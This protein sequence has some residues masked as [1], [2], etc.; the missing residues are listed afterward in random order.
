MGIRRLEYLSLTTKILVI[1]NNRVYHGDVM[2]IGKE[3]RSCRHGEIDCSYSR[4]RFQE[5][6]GS[7]CSQSGDDSITHDH[8]SITRDAE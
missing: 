4:V 5:L 8:E 6:D 1:R 3:L 7:G 2:G